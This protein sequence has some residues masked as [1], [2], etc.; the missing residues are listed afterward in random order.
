MRKNRKKIIEFINKKGQYILY[1]IVFLDFI[2]PL[3]FWITPSQGLNEIDKIYNLFS[4]SIFCLLPWI[5]P[6]FLNLF[7]RM[8]VEP[9]KKAYSK[10]KLKNFTGMF[11][12]FYAIL[13]FSSSRVIDF[14]EFNEQSWIVIN[15]IYI[16]TGDIYFIIL[17]YLITSKYKKTKILITIVIFDLFSIFSLMWRGVSM[18]LHETLQLLI[19]VGIVGIVGIIASIPILILFLIKKKPT[20][21]KSFLLFLYIALFAY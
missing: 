21:I 11:D 14:M 18:K 4:I 12:F 6:V 2:I 1:A 9:G 7:N 3:W 5:L 13:F 17:I 8:K 16:I 20:S 15:L 19:I 10:D